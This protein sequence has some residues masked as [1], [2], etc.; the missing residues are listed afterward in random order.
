MD[1][2][3]LI[4]FGL[5]MALLFGYLF[6]NQKQG[7]IIRQQKITDSIAAAKLNP[8]VIKKDSVQQTQVA[9]AG[10]TLD[11]NFQPA[12][13]YTIQNKDLIL[14]L[15]NKGAMLVSAQLPK[16]KAARPVEARK[17]L[18]V[19]NEN[20][21]EL[22]VTYN[23]A[24]GTVVHSK[25]MMFTAAQK[26]NEV[27]F[28]NPNGL[29]V[30]YTLP[31]SGYNVAIK[32][33]A[34]A[35]LG[36][37]QAM[38]II[39]NA[40]APNNEY[41]AQDD[42]Q[43]TQM[44]YN[45]NKDGVDY[46]T[47]TG[48]K[49]ES[50]SSGAKWLCF[51]QHYFNTTIM[52][53]ANPFTKAELKAAPTADTSNNTVAKLTSTMSLP[54]G[55][56]AALNMYVGPNDYKILKAQGNDMQEIIPYGYGFLSFV[57]YI[58]KWFMMPIFNTLSKFFSNWGLVIMFLTVI[59]RLIT[60]PLIYKSYVSGAKMKVLKPELDAMKEQMKD[61]QQGFAMKQMEFYRSA[62][63][64]PLGGCLPALLQLPIFFALLS[65]FPNAIELRQ[66]PFLWAKDLSTFDSIASIPSIPFYGDH[67]S[68]WT[69][70]FV[71]TQLFLAL[72][73][74]NMATTDQNNP[75][76]KW[77]PFIMPVMFLGIFNKLP[78]SLTFYYCV[79]NVITIILQIVI[80]KF[81]INEDKLKAK[82]LE[83]RSKEPKQ[84][85]LMQQMM[86]A[87]KQKQQQAKK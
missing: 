67:I 41:S 68:L 82:L 47:L 51:K 37:S 79:S 80:Q 59:V 1:K 26:A 21:N 3:S 50:L 10:Q 39:W 28:T 65:L 77:L 34:G 49:T 43:Y 12:A 45:E 53:T 29:S 33:N 5:M 78:A 63:V 60:S 46:S 40:T 4:G 30:T 74:M 18:F 15:S 48:E 81:I 85:K 86:E 2:N 22:D 44:V 7:E 32:L 52:A 35:S 62:G 6:Y 27:V 23:S 87:A 13:T 69:L 73:S 75:M 16:F 31:D 64:N 8:P 20:Q 14:V 9:V 42:L 25:D 17:P 84:N 24:T 11:S 58:N 76:L 70:L 54:V 72:Y 66:Q 36:A 57:K 38:S 83:N 71:A 19:F 55:A 61:D 56:S